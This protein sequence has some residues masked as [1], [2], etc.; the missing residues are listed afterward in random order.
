MF[1]W[2]TLVSLNRFPFSCLFYWLINTYFYRAK[3]KRVLSCPAHLWLLQMLC[4]LLYC[5]YECCPCYTWQVW[6]HKFDGVHYEVDNTYN[7]VEC[8]DRS[9]CLF[10]TKFYWK[11]IVTPPEITIDQMEN[12]SA[13]NNHS[14]PIEVVD[15]KWD[16]GSMLKLKRKSRSRK[17]NQHLSQSLKLLFVQNW[18]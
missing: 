4:V 1:V 17:P 2:P 13:E 16:G 15:E 7:F 3:E 10:T 8:W 18:G 5:P 6:M 9:M 11:F 12:S 14:K